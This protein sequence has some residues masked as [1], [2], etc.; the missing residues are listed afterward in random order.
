MQAEDDVKGSVAVGDIFGGG[1]PDRLVATS[2]EGMNTPEPL[3]VY[4]NLRNPQ[5]NHGLAIV[6]VDQQ[7]HRLGIGSRIVVTAGTGLTVTRQA[8]GGVHQFSPD[9]GIQHLGKSASR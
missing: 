5:N 4:R 8:N 3:L 1:N 2:I 6:D 7:N 9:S